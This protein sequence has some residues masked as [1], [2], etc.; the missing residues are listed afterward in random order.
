MLKYQFK[1][2]VNHYTK[3]GIPFLFI[4]D[5]D[6]KNPQVYRLDELDDKNIFFALAEASYLPNHHFFKVDLT[7]KKLFINQETYKKAFKTVKEQIQKGNSYLL[8]LT[9]KNK[10]VFDDNK[11]NLLHI[12]DQ[13]KAKY[14][15]FYKDKFVCFSPETFIKIENNR[16]KTFP[17]KGTIDAAIKNAAQ[18]LLN[19]VKESREHNTIVDLLR[20]DLAIVATDIKVERFKYLEKISTQKGEILQ[21]SSEISGKLPNNWKNN[22]G[23]IIL[24]LLP[25]GSVTGAPKPKT[26]EI[27][28]NVENY[29]RKFYTGI[30]GVFDGENV[31]SGVLIRFIEKEGDD[32]YYKSGGGITYLSEMKS[33]YKE[34]LQKIYIPI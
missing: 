31:D 4:V 15:L 23:D 18:K 8:N 17:M 6:I 19:D 20:N 3:Q 22:F 1:K 16:I 27:I 26:V 9:F 11:V 29:Q 24:K 10:I 2:T 33:E 5:F 28:K 7:F 34:L 13:T 32:F 14:K 25:A 21:M 12:F 30:F